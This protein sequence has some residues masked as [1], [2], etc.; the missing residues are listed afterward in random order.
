LTQIALFEFDSQACDL[1]R[2]T[3]LV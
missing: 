3:N 2:F 1:I